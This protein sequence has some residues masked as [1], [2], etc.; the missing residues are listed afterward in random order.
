MQ[1]V[2]G[3]AG[4]TNYQGI[5]NSAIVLA[6]SSVYLCWNDTTNSKLQIAVSSDAP[7]AGMGF[8]TPYDVTGGTTGQIGGF[9]PSLKVVGTTVYVSYADGKSVKLASSSN[10]TTWTYK[11]IDTDPTY[12]VGATALTADTAGHLLWSVADGSLTLHSSNSTDGLTMANW[13]ADASLAPENANLSVPLPFVSA[14][15]S[16]YGLSYQYGGSPGIRLATSTNGGST[17]SFQW[18]DQQVG[19][20]G[21]MVSL[22]VDGQNVYAVNDTLFAPNQYSITMKKSLDCGV[23]W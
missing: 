12:N 3:F 17:W 8:G 16:L 1:N 23:T 18:L 22:A 2:R 6:N 19:N 9:Y 10:L 5:M 11:T 15:G 4:E 13:S 20:S 14:G 21:A 7:P